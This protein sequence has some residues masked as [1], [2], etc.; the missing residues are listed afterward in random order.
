M[1]ALIENEQNSRNTQILSKSTVHS[2]MIPQPLLQEYKHIHSE[3]N[4]AFRPVNTDKQAVVQKM[5]TTLEHPDDTTQVTWSSVHN[6]R[7]SVS[8][9]GNR[10][11]YWKQPEYEDISNDSKAMD[12]DND[13]DE[14]IDVGSS[15]DTEISTLNITDFAE[16]SSTSSI[17]M[18]NSSTVRNTSKVD[19][20]PS[21]E[22]SSLRLWRPAE[23]PTK[24]EVTV[25]S[26]EMESSTPGVDSNGENSSL[27]NE[28]FQKLPEG[29]ITKIERKRPSVTSEMPAKEDISPPLSKINNH[30]MYPPIMKNID[31]KTA[32]SFGLNWRNP[33]HYGYNSDLS[34]PILKS[35]PSIGSNSDSINS[36]KEVI[37][38][39]SYYPP[40]ALSFRRTISGYP[41]E[42]T[43]GVFVTKNDILER[44]RSYGGAGLTKRNPL[45]IRSYPFEHSE[46]FNRRQELL[47]RR[48][49]NMYSINLSTRSP[50]SLC[51]YRTDSSDSLT[52]SSQ[53]ILS[54]RS[55]FGSAD[56]NKISNLSFSSRNSSIADEDHR[57]HIASS[58]ITDAMTTDFS[59]SGESF[60]SPSTYNVQNCSSD[61]DE[62]FT[63]SVDEAVQEMK[64]IKSE[65]SRD[66]CLAKAND[67]AINASNLEK[68]VSF[69]GVKD[70]QVEQRRQSVVVEP[71]S[72][73][74]EFSP[75]DYALRNRVLVL[76]WVLLGERRLVREVGYPTEPVHRLLWRA[77]DVCC[78]VAGVKSAAAVPLNSDHDCGSDMLCFRDH[79]HRFLEVC[80][81]TREHWKQFGWAS[82]T[83]DAV[84]RKIYQEELMPLL[85]IESLP[86]D[87]QK[88]AAY[89]AQLERPTV[90]V[91]NPAQTVSYKSEHKQQTVVI[92]TKKKRGR[93]AK[94]THKIEE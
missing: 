49:N 63:D 68:P 14:E 51:S 17:D 10:R 90:M 36:I 69:I 75:D 5:L 44:R 25:K 29:V 21:S 23:V 78:S 81:P 15:Y 11:H 27:K 20:P 6:Y 60:G 83:V 64:V 56:L 16:E 28:P 72:S 65:D 67:S 55:S 89:L 48:Q 7:C 33:Q 80:A 47:Q 52:C 61:D 39:S 57:E 71:K 58:P 19:T 59:D 3:H 38:R 91:T 92:P 13:E 30:N 22:K 93:P 40:S 2:T 87:I 42:N 26:A 8:V 62:A 85:R 24:K 82:L 50:D 34:S 73:K 66:V 76:L 70:E 4:S 31:K 37:L 79:T 45:H 35:P 1:V 84:V 77:V 54:R 88:S 32:E 43:E 41:I 18:D 74:E 94:I 46:T 53:G 9:S 86:P 12:D